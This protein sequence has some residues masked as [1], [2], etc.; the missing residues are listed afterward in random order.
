MMSNFDKSAREITGGRKKIIH[1]DDV[2]YSLISVK[3]RLSKNFE[4]FAV[5]SAAKLYELLESIIPDLILLDADMPDVDGYETIK[6]LKANDRLAQIPVVFLTGKCD[7]E[8]VVKGLSLG[9]ADYI[10]KPFETERLIETL[11][12]I[13]SPKGYELS[14]REGSNNKPGVLAVDDVASMLRA[15]QYALHDRYNVYLLSKPEG[16]PNFLKAEKPD[17]ILLDYLMPTMSGF[18]LISIIKTI[19]EHKDTPIIILT[20]EGTGEHVKEAINL[21][22]SDFIVKPFNP[23]E[24]NDKVAKHIRI[25]NELRIIREDTGQFR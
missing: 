17:L 12:N 6:V 9:A 8:S 2:N 23:K 14:T 21:G 22:A 10:F 19:P 18:D 1:V 4:I 16:V 7:R 20:T 3:S 11:N 25:A 15:I 5:N 13:L 24:L